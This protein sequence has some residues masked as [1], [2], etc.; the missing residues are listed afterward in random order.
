[1]LDDNVKLYVH[2]NGWYRFFILEQYMKKWYDDNGTHFIN[3]CTVG[4]TH[5]MR[6]II[7]IRDTDTII[8]ITL[9]NY[10]NYSV[11]YL[12]RSTLWL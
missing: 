1:M 3:K 7:Q 5:D 11:G 8:V 12:L 4:L 6:A 10:K 9:E 2:P